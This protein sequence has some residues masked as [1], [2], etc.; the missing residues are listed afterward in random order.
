MRF[1]AV[2]ASPAVLR[3]LP[4]LARIGCI[5]EVR[6]DAKVDLWTTQHGRITWH[7][8][9]RAREIRSVVRRAALAHLR[10]TG[11]VPV[12]SIESISP[13]GLDHARSLLEQDGRQSDQCYRHILLTP[14]RD[15]ALL[16]QC[17]K[18]LCATG[19]LPIDELIS[20]LRRTRFV[21]V[22]PK[23][24]R[25]LLTRAGGFSFEGDVISLIGSV[26]TSAILSPAEQLGFALLRE[27][28]GA[29]VW[30][31]FVEAM[32]AGGFSAPMAS[33][34]VRR[35]AVRSIGPGIYGLRGI[36]IPRDR[37][38]ALRRRR[39]ELAGDHKVLTHVRILEPDVIEAT[40]VLNRFSLQGVVPTPKSFDRTPAVWTAEFP[41]GSMAPLKSGNGFLWSLAPYFRKLAG[42]GR[43]GARIVA[44]FHLVRRVV[45]VGSPTEPEA[46]SALPPARSRQEQIA[47]AVFNGDV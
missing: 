24:L 26:D 9:G 7:D 8:S 5:P 12:A 6:Y 31:D 35:A 27:N 29:M 18:T 3:V 22:E 21:D 33:I 34:V 46:H 14:Q 43:V 10:I 25:V 39:R 30:W 11:A 20:G 17:R 4:A 38:R 44:R 37:W 42:G 19:P 47:R 28:A 36:E 1:S 45:T 16:R 15:C 32:V 13:F 41:D 40:Y 2:P 23:L